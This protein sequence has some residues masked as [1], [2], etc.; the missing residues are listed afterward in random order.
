MLAFKKKRSELALDPSELVSRAYTF[1]GRTRDGHALKLRPHPTNRYEPP[2][3][4]PTWTP[5]ESR[6]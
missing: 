1:R 6:S 3:D 4:P 5:L 2:A